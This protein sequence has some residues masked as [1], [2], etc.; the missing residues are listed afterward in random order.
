MSRGWTCGKACSFFRADESVLRLDY[1]DGLVAQLGKYTNHPPASPKVSSFH[2][3]GLEDQELIK[4]RTN[5]DFKE[6]ATKYSL[7]PTKK[8][9]GM[10]L[11]LESGDRDL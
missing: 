3:I 11:P 10:S 4:I 1:G 2:H 9:G 6:T 7:W 8:S 5:F